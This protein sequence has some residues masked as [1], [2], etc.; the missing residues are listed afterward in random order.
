MKTKLILN[1]VSGTDAASGHLTLINERFRQHGD[2]LDIVITVGEGDATRAATE[3]VHDDY[4]Q[5]LVAGGDGTLNEAL[6]GVGAVADGFARVIFGLIPLGTGNDFATAMGVPDDIDAAV[7][8]LRARGAELVGE[9]ERYKDRYR[10]CYV[11]G[12]EGIIVEL[13]EQIG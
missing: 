3:A 13:T 2:T 8:G 4:D 5:L 7:A 10:L 11:R 1:P 12:P 9:V 6:N